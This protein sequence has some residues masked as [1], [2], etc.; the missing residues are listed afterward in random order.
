MAVLNDNNQI[1]CLCRVVKKGYTT[2]MKR[3]QI[4]N[5]FYFL[6]SCT[7]YVY[8]TASSNELLCSIKQSLSGVLLFFSTLCFKKKTYCII[9]W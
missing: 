5:K 2:M 4:K 8:F 6:C 7:L 3:A 1:L 9:P